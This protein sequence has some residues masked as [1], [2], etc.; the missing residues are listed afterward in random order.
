MSATSRLRDGV[1]GLLGITLVL[2]AACGGSNAPAAGPPG[3]M[4]PTGVKTLTLAERPIAHASDFV[5]TVQSL[6]STTVQPQAEGRIT[7]I[8]VKS[9]DRIR[10]GAPIL[11]IEPDLM[12]AAGSTLEASRAA[13]DAEVAYAT[14]QL[15]RA[16]KLFEA[17]AVS[18]QELDQAETAFKTAS[19]QLEALN[20][21]VREWRVELGYYRLTAPTA[22]IVG[23]IPVRVGDRVTESTLI[24]TIDENRGLEAHIAVPLEQATRLKIGLPV[25]LLDNDGN[26]LTRSTI[27]FVAPRAEDA[28][29]SVL[30]KSAI[31]AGMPVRVLQYIRAR[32][33]WTTAPGL[34][35]PIVAVSR[36]SGA[37]FCFV[38][39]PHEKGFVAR[40][41]P[42]LVGEVIGDDYAVRSGLKAGERVIVSGVQ[43]LGDGAPVQPE[44]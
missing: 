4:P 41:R 14:Q 38:A 3:G 31:P 20:A 2:A 29:Q 18:R 37:Y 42:I 15:E 35:I 6:R 33:I 17:G 22:G 43:K 10:A 23:D 25:E 21:Q 11:Q 24:T 44:G 13:R 28:T 8:H 32:I 26:V 40:Q 36:V 7:R 12:Q 5:G 27:T 1:G 30:A 39:E 19:A 16:R 9:G 34:A